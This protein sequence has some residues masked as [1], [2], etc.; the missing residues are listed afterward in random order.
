[1]ESSASIVIRVFIPQQLAKG[2]AV[3]SKKFEKRQGH[4][5]RET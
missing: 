2:D 1:M 3:L 4:V 5:R